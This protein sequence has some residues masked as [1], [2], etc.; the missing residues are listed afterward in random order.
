MAD[1]PIRI[2]RPIFNGDNWNPMMP[3]EHQ[4]LLYTLISLVLVM[5]TFKL[6]S[7]LLSR[8]F[9]EQWRFLLFSP[10]LAISTYRRNRP[11]SLHRL[12]RVC[13]GLALY[14]AITFGFMVLYKTLD[15]QG[16][17]KSYGFVP[18]MYFGCE[19]L[20]RLFQLAFIPSGRIAAN[21]FNHPLYSRSLTEFWGSRWN[22]W[23]SDWY[24]EVFL[25]RLKLSRTAKIPTIYVFTGLWHDLVFTVPYYIVTGQNFMGR[26]TLYFIL[27]T[28]FIF[29][30]RRLFRTN[31]L[32]RRLYFL[33]AI[34]GPIPILCPYQMLEPIRLGFI[35]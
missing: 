27:Q 23:I 14:S 19:A 33:I 12:F 1:I 31:N 10:V 34:A 3:A 32:W 22:L 18:I 26:M 11:L 20:S 25:K 13:S 24:R 5:H 35:P 17:W 16:H 6:T 30:D 21:F 7:L 15:L 4:T 29:G 2:Y 9:D 28:L 8:G